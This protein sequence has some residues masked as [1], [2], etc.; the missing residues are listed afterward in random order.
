[1]GDSD[2]IALRMMSVVGWVSCVGIAWLGSEGRRHVPWRTVAWG[3][4]LQVLLALMLL[5]TAVGR[6]LFTQ[7]NAMVTALLAYSAQGA[8][9][10]FGD[11]ALSSFSV[12]LHVLPVIV[13]FAALSAVLFHLGVLQ[14]VVGMFA[15]LMR[16]TMRTTGTETLAVASNVF[17]GM[18]EAPLLIRPYLPMLSRSEL[19]AVMVGGMGT[20]A[21]A[22]LGAYVGLLRGTIPDI[23]G[24]LLTASV[25][26]APIA[27]VMAKILVPPAPGTAD[28]DKNG[29][30]A[31]KAQPDTAAKAP[32]SMHEIPQEA[33]SPPGAKEP[34]EKDAFR[35]QNVVDA[36]TRGATEG[37][38]LA[39]HVGAM[40]L[41]FVALVALMN[42]MLAW[43]A[44]GAESLLGFETGTWTLE[45]MGAWVFYPVALLI[46]IPMHEAFVVAQLL[47][48]K[49]VFNEMYAYRHLAELLSVEASVGGA[50][51]VG[52]V[53]KALSPRTAFMASYALCGF[54]NIGSVAILVGG[55]GVLAPSRRSELAQLGWR[56]V[57]GG[58]LVSLMNAALVGVMQ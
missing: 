11:A 22:V 33:P 16:R 50:A 57:L 10:V 36:A 7:A 28:K 12:A 41:A 45:A 55:V 27:L 6:W 17:L 4:A 52:A 8:A 9:F 3:L 13:F 1:M 18:T 5:Q 30:P 44:D 54:A 2:S 43:L 35:A 42:G 26:S 46:G 14:R 58:T 24:H 29:A 34:E 48:E 38:H 20:V 56:A 40:L 49:I 23:A 51:A 19:M 53:G 21:G 37:M 25:M 39:L 47:G 15:W 32:S 31:D